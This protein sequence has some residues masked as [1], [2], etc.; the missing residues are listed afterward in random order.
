MFIDSLVKELRNQ[1]W[2]IISVEEAY[3]DKMYLEQPKNTYANNGIIAQVG[4]EK[5]GEKV[6]YNHFDELKAELIKILGL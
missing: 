6:G 3:K 5:T 4:M 2:K 1:G